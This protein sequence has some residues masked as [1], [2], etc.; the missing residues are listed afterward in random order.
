MVTANMV[1]EGAVV[2]DVGV[3]RKED[4]SLCGDVDFDN[5][6]NLASFITPSPGGVGPMTV[7]MLMENTIKAYEMQNK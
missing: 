7:A 5:V 2:I 4:G 1:K 6:K 3:S